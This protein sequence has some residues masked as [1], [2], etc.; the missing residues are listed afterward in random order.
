M[1]LPKGKEK[2]MRVRKIQPVKV[3]INKKLKVCA[4]ARVSTNTAK[5]E[6]SLENQETYFN[7]MIAANPDYEYAGI[8]IDQG[9]SGYYDKRPEFQKMLVKARNGE[10]DLII[11]KSVS[12]FGRNTVTILKTVRELRE[13]GVSIFFEEQNINTM[14]GDGEVLLTVLSSLAQEESR[15]ISEN[16]KWS[17]RKKF[18]RGEIMINATRFLG[19][20]MDETGDFVINQKQAEIIRMIYE[21]YLSGKGSFTIAK[22]MNEDGIPTITG[23]EW[24]D[25]AILNILKNEKYKGD[26]I[27]Q[28]YFTPEYKRNQT[29]R[30]RGQ[31][32]SFYIE[33]NHPAIIKREYWDRVQQMMKEKSESRNV[34]KKKYQNRYPLSGLLF[35]SKCG[36]AL[37]RR[38]V[39]GGKVQWIC[40]TY[41][42]KGKQAC[43]GIRLDDKEVCRLNIHEPTIVKEEIIH[44][45]KHHTYTSKSEYERRNLGSQSDEK[46]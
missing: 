10:I 27:L 44:G 42:R 22:E 3:D 18:S 6:G 37:H 30:N 9:V 33:D 11:T 8:F 25:S 12:R 45:K 28:K 43:S 36:K 2:K 21:K 1:L 24:D 20:D 19:Y 14:S 34:D 15:S 26:Y 41:I 29:V 38:Q 17:I 16:N 40:N 5:Q 4:Y 32:D 23:G 31:V 7:R 39:Y 35:C 46:N 13:L